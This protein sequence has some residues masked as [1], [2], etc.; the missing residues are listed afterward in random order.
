M[1]VIPVKTGTQENWIPAFAGM[2]VFA[3]MTIFKRMNTKIKKEND[4]GKKR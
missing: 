3:G 2:T 1:Y 4:N